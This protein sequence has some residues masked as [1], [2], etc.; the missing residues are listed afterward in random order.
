M[1]VFGDDSLDAL[2][3]LHQDLIAVT[4]SRLPNIER[5]AAELESRVEEL[6]KLLQKPTKND[7]SRQ[8]LSS[9]AYCLRGRT[10]GTDP[11]TRHYQA[12]A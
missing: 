1:A 12:G 8:T 9:G 5:L 4:A 10:T 11:V 2:K 3:G 7:K 6:K